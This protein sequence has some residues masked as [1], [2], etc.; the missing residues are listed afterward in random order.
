MK[1]FQY[2]K[3]KDPAWFQENR[4]AAHSDHRYYGSMEEMEQ[5]QENFRYSLNGLWKFHYANNYHSTIPG[6][7]SMDYCCRSW[8]DIHVPA[9]IQME[10]YDRPQYANVQYPWE[11][12]EE[13]EPGQIP[14]RFNPVASYVKYFEVPENMKGKRVF[15]SFQGA[16]S[17]IAV[18]LN[19]SYVGYSEDTFTPS[20]FELTPYLQEGENKLAAQ[21][22]KFTSSSWCEDQDFFRFSGIYRD[23]YLYAVPEVHVEDMRIRTLLDDTFTKADLEIVLKATAKGSVKIA[24]SKDGNV[25]MTEESALG[26]DTRLVMKVDNPALWSAESPVLYDLLF[27][28]FDNAGTLTEVIPYRVGFRRFEMKDNIM[29]LNGRRIVFK[30]VNR[31]EFSSVSGRHV[32]REELVKDIVTMKRNNI[33][34]I[35]TCHYPDGSDIY[36]LC[37]EYG[38]YMIAENNLE[39]HGSW[40]SQ[41]EKKEPDLNKVVPCDHPEWLGMMLD[42]VNSMYQRDKNHTAILIWSCG[43]ESFGGKDIYEMS[44]FYRKEDPTRLVHYEGVFWDRRYNGSSDMESQMYPSVE[45]IKAFLEKDRSKPFICCEY[46]H[47]MGNSC[48]AMHKYTDLTDTE[49]LY[50]GGFIW[51]YI[52]QSIYKKD[53]YGKEFLAYGGDFDDRPCDYNFSGNG[54]AYGGDRMPSPKMQEVKFNYQNI[55]AVVEKDKVRVVNKNL[56]VNTDSFDCV[57][58]VEKDGHLLREAGLETHVA[59]LSEEVYELPVSVQTLPGEYAVT[60]S[61]RLRE[62]TL[63]A[64]RGHEVAFGQGVYEVPAP[65]A[66]HRGKMEIVKSMHN[67]GIHGDGFRI[68]FSYLNGGLVSYVYGGVEMIKAIPKPNFWR[69]PTDNDC[70]NLMPMRYGQWKLASMYLNHKDPQGGYRIPKLEVL[71]D[72]AVITYT[73]YMPSIPSA[74]CSLAYRVYGDGTVETTLSYDPVKELGDMPEFGVMFKFDADYDNVAWYGM[75]PEE[76]YVDRCL[77]AKLGIYKN[78]V[79]DNMA[80]YLVPQECGNKV[81]VRWASVTD[82]KGRGML[83]TGDKME[84]SALPYTP[85]E[86]ENAMHPFELPEVHYTVVRVSAKQMGVA[87]DDS[88]GSKTHPEYLLNTDGRMEFTFSFKGV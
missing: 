62:D 34:A 77:G 73:Y 38:L 81:G 82:R 75:G 79:A 55:T 33:N 43:N 1:A 28:V 45:S 6:F 35:R 41:A 53:R 74:E 15:I 21:V 27:Q 23:V 57:V 63:W 88:W 56:F 69:A 49:P 4:A 36:D 65:A 87:G 70:G 25:L 84:F 39:S 13:L 76:T 80:E 32:S 48:G 47:A 17:G 5:K 37:D 42:R 7:E 64:K 9:H 11:G 54:I 44:E 50:Q 29:M 40:D 51:D 30:G 67:I 58:L 22:F 3:V 72:S 86:I 26:S 60:V 18:W 66:L 46:T 78:K 10:G 83:F 2:E 68:L 85:H 59:P 8:D 31:H 20:E 61:F 14:T 52:D 16:E 24:L 19:G 12:W 71:E